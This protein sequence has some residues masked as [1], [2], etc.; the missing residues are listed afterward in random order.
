[1]RVFLAYRFDQASRKTIDAVK[2]RLRAQAVRGRFTDADN[3]H[4]TIHFLGQVEDATL[5][6]IREAIRNIDHDVFTIRTDAI[7]SFSRKR[8]NIYYL[9]VDPSKPLR[10]VHRQTA[11]ALAKR[12]FELPERDYHPHITLARHAVL[13]GEP[14]IHVPPIHIPVKR[15]YLMESTHENGRLVYKP[16]FYN[17]LGSSRR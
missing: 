8:G 16:V 10:S 3:L 1:M 6:K 15:I 7:G 9:K 5:L 11:V 12:G 17:N 14:N 13:K 4:V 2:Q